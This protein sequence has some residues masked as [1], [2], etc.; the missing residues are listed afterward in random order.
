MRSNSSVKTIWGFS[1]CSPRVTGALDT[2]IKTQFMGRDKQE[3]IYSFQLYIFNLMRSYSSVK[4]KQ[5]E[6]SHTCFRVFGMWHNLG[7]LGWNTIN[8]KLEHKI[9]QILN[10]IRQIKWSLDTEIIWGWIYICSKV[11]GTI[12]Q[13]GETG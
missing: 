1:Y 11:P 5:V 10:S 12:G 7:K 2:G 9:I 4:A 6:V 3:V 8:H 13:F